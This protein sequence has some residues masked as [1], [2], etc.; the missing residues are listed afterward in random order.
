MAIERLQK[1]LSRGG[2]SSRRA[3]EQLITGGRVRINGRIVTEL[4]TKADWA[5]DRI[6]VDGKRV[7]AEKPVYI[8]L[9][10]PRGVVATLSDPEGRPTVADYVRGISARIYPIGRLD[11]AT[12][13][14]LLA[15]NDGDFA[16]GLMHPRRK[17]PK[18]Y[19]LKVKGVMQPEDIEKWR[20]G[21]KLEDGITLPAEAQLLR[22][23]GDKTWLELTIHEGRNQQI[24]RMGEA[25]GF[26]VMRLARTAFAGISSDELRPG[27][28]RE[29]TR[30]ELVQLKK[31]FGVP[32][33]I[34]AGKVVE[35]KSKGA[36]R[37]MPTRPGR[38]ATAG[39]GRGPREDDREHTPRSAWPAQ[40]DERPARQDARRGAPMRDERPARPD[41]RRGAPMRD[42]R[43]ARPDA[44]RTDRDRAPTAPRP[45][46]GTA[47]KKT[48]PEGRGN[49][50]PRQKKR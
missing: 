46:S 32:K 17:V 27:S 18:T 3:A 34:S 19:V 28:W 29:L 48:S 21:I 36:T 5:T 45:T 9:H 4:G 31:E 42:E 12:S 6:E 8:V 13:G 38:P 41:A 22:H 39:R 26:L 40:R 23:E 43:P 11:F 7:V 33:R 16:D 44:R 25:T 50:Q 37:Q 47:Q 15:T 35:D 1:I 20:R 24:R 10:K 2:I 49:A 30:E 14:V